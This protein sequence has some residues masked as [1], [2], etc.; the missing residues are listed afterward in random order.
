MNPFAKFG[1]RTAPVMQPYMEG[2]SPPVEELQD[3]RL[4]SLFSMEEQVSGM[5]D[6]GVG[7]PVAPCQRPWMELALFDEA[8][9]PLPQVPYQILVGGVS[10]S[11]LLDERGFVHLDDVAPDLSNAGV[12]VGVEMDEEGSIQKYEVRVVNKEKDPEEM[13]IQRESEVMD[14]WFPSFETL[15]DH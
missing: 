9:K 11:G 14:L 5:S 8:M 1:K 15:E 10:R 2:E 7:D 13:E 12:E 4:E 6:Q 3:D